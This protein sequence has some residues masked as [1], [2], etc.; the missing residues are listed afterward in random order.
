MRLESI[1]W[2]GADAATLARRLRRLAPSLTEVTSDGRARSSTRSLSA[3]TTRSASS[4]SA[5][6]RRR[7]SRCASTRSSSAASRA[8]R[9]PEVREALARCGRATSRRWPAPRPRPRCGRSR[10]SSRGASGSRSRA[11]PVAS[12]GVYAPGGRGA[13]PSSVLMCAIPARAAGVAQDRGRYAGRRRRPPRATRCSPPA[14]S[15]GSTR[16]TRSAALRRSPRSR[17]GTDT[18][19]AVDVVVGPGNRY[20]TEAKRLLAG[21]VG[22]DGIAGPSE[23]AVVAD[24]TADPSWL[25]LDLC[26]QAEHGDDGLLVVVSPD[27]GAARPGRR[28]GRPRSPPSG[29]S[30]AAPAL[31]LVDRAGAR[32]RPEPR[33]RARPRAPRAR[34]PGRRRGERPRPG[35]RLRVRRRRRRD[36]VRRL[37]RRAPTTSC[38]PAARPASGGRSARALS[39]GARPSFTSAPPRQRNWRRMW[40]RSRT[41]R[42]S[43]CTASRRS[44]G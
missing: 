6:A 18:V 26:A 31:A 20:V 12:A 38:R 3:A 27:A 39:C 37:R 40:P 16:C 25:A 13:Y 35:R 43:R 44:R 36:G 29:P 11:S 22:I 41:P 19:A 14:R 10:S 34:L 2:D 23:L 5:S 30:V 8:A 42:A 15:P 28:A 9:A 24:G 4:P 17:F 33:R 32:A 1:E 21:A 7:R